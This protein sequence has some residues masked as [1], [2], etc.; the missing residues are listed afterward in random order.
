ML[1]KTLY[2]VL[3]LSLLVFIWSPMPGYATLPAF[4]GEGDENE[5]VTA[6]LPSNILIPDGLK[7]TFN[8]LLKRSATFRQQCRRINNTGNLRI[9]IKVVPSIP[10]GLRA[11]SVVSRDNKGNVRIILQTIVMSDYI[12]ML[13]HEFEHALEQ[14]EG[15]DLRSLASKG[16]DVYQQWNGTFET[17]RAVRTGR[18]VASEFRKSRN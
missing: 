14:V 6:L 13:G 8:K 2:I 3:T 12:E 7:P 1:E 11:Q 5:E 18:I 16:T 10:N 15:L 17:G 4:A 9:M